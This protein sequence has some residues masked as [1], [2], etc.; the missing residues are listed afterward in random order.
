[1]LTDWHSHWLPPALI[2]RL[3]RRTAAP[4]IERSSEGLRLI[5]GRRARLLPEVAVNLGRRRQ[6]LAELGIDRQI[7]SLSSLWN[8][9]NLP[10]QDALPLVRS[11]NDAVGEASLSSAGIFGGYAALPLNDM[12]MACAELERCGRLG[13][14]GVIMPAVAF[15]SRTSAEC[16]APLLRIADDLGWRVF[17]HPGLLSPAD[18]EPA[19]SL[20]NAWL[21][22]IVLAAQQQ[23]S[24]AMMTLCGTSLLD[25]Y[26]RLTVQLANLGGAM[27]FLLERLDS[28]RR[29]D[30]QSGEEHPWT[31]KRIAVDTASFGPHAIALARRRMGAHS[32]I[33]GTDMPVFDAGHAL[34]AWCAVACNPATC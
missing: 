29:D 20:D 12:Q 31:T 18:P 32:V 27:P 9:D 1:M 7:L 30:P 16:F 6:L 26:P 23:L 17:V 8:I 11:F 13:L 24:E 21:R 2:E 22:Y 10:A 33:L 28:V 5:T 4:R 19:R 15:S 25:H 3:A 34:A 14:E